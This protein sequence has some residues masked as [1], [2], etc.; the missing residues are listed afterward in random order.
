MGFPDPGRAE[1][2]QVVA[3]LDIAASSKFTDLLGI[4][5]RLELEVEALEGLLEREAR[6]RDA[7]LMVLVGFRVNLAGEQLVEEVGVGKF[8]FR[9]LLQARGQFL[10]DLIEPQPLTLFAQ[11]FELG[12]AHR[13]SPPAPRLMASYSWRSRTSTS[14]N[15]LK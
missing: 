1:Q 3:A 13:T 15:P 6:H 10:F 5:R 7:H 14:P 2:Q 12:R 9:G 11:A 8:L 4:E